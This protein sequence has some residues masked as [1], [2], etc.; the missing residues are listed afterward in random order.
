MTHVVFNQQNSHKAQINP[1]WTTKKNPIIS[2]KYQISSSPRDFIKFLYNKKIHLFQISPSPPVMT[3]TPYAS[4]LQVGWHSEGLLQVKQKAVE[5]SSSGNNEALICYKICHDPSSLI[6]SCTSH[7]YC[8]PQIWYN[9]FLLHPGPSLTCP[10]LP[11]LDLEL[12]EPW[13][14]AYKASSRHAW[15]S[16]GNRHSTSGKWSKETIVK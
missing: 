15:L 8:S 4:R 11:W 13:W 14:I 9:S 7:A 6:L 10:H 3:P 5:S 1:T 16:Y 2:P 12:P